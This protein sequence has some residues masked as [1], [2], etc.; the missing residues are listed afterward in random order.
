MRKNKNSKKTIELNAET[1]SFIKEMKRYTKQLTKSPDGCK[2]VLV[3]A[4][5]YTKNG[6]LRKAFNK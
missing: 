3:K 1:V 6:N 5:I 2:S 4:G